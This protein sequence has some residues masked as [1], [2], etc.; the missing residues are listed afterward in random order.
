MPGQRKSSAKPTSPA[1][2]AAKTSSAN[3]ARR[4]AS[5]LDALARVHVRDRAAWREWLEANHA[6]SPGIWLVF[7]KKSAGRER[8]A[9]GDAVEEAL[10][11]GWIDSL[12]RS[13]DATQY[14]QLFTPRKPT[15][16]WSRSNKERVERL[17]TA[18]LLR[19]AG[20]AAIEIAQR[21]GAWSRL[22]SA[23]ALEIPPDLAQAL[24][25]QRNARRHFDA[26]PPSARRAYLNWVASAKRPETRASRIRTVAELASKNQKA[27]TPARKS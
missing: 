11:F 16:G 6:A 18:G 10:C 5:K 15:S 20:I 8:L 2:A 26:F 14:Q 21:N 1:P 9:Y 27:P 23:D 7:D 3:R 22:D 19:P 13:L 24:G 17:R 12:T 25:R 4:P